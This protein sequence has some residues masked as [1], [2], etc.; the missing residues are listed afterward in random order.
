MKKRKRN[1]FTKFG[2]TVYSTY[3]CIK[4]PFL[5]PRNRFT[6]LHYTNWRI[7]EK[8][9]DLY[10]EAYRFGTMEEHF[11]S[12]VINKRKALLCKLIKWYH[13]KFLQVVHCIPKWNELDALKNDAPGWYKAFGFQMCKEIK[14][15]LLDDGGRKLLRAYRITQIKEKYGELRW[16]TYGETPET[17]RII[18]KYTY[19]SRHT[20]IDCVKSAT[21]MTNGYILPYCDKCF[22]GSPAMKTDYYTEELPFYG[23]YK[24]RNKKKEED[25]NKDESNE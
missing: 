2:H 19:I 4:Y 25:G 14:K 18:A 17:D 1:I 22:T 6:G 12:Q 13:D 20:C 15:A 16:Y 10:N 23:H 7:E 11:K 8:L 3:L 21:C 5:Y 9:G 24:I